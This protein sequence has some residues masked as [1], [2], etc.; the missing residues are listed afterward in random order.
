MISAAVR[1]RPR[2]G[3]GSSSLALRAGSFG[4]ESLVRKSGEVLAR[5]L[6]LDSRKRWMPSGPPKV[7]VSPKAVSGMMIF[8]L[9]SGMTVCAMTESGA[10]KSTS[11]IRKEMRSFFIGCG[12]LNI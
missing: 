10:H 11:A 4:S 6:P 7:L 12:L 8:G 1:R 9:N 2:F 5:T 3:F